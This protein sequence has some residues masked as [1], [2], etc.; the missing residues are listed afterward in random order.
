MKNACLEDEYILNKG[1]KNGMDASK[2]RDI[3]V[4]K[5][6]RYKAILIDGE[7]GIGK[8]YEIRKCVEENTKN[9]FYLSLF[10]IE[11]PLSIYKSMLLEL[12]PMEEKNKRALN[13]IQSIAKDIGENISDSIETKGIL[14]GAVKSVVSSIVNE[15]SI[16]INRLSKIKD[17]IIVFD[18]MERIDDSVSMVC[19]LG[20]LEELKKHTNIVVIANLGKMSDEHKKNLDDYT[21]KIFGKVY[22]ITQCSKII[23]W[24]ELGVDETAKMLFED[25]KQ[26]LNLRVLQ[27]GQYLFDDLTLSLKREYSHEFLEFIHQI[28]YE[29]VVEE[30][31]SKNVEN[32]FV[33]GGNKDRIDCIIDKIVKKY[34]QREH[35]VSYHIIRNIYMYFINGESINEEEFYAESHIYD[36][37]LMVWRMSIDEVE[38]IN[39]KIIQYMEEANEVYE[40]DYLAKK[41]IQ[42][43]NFT[44]KSFDEGLLCYKK[45]MKKILL[46]I[47]E[48]D[49]RYWEKELNREKT[50]ISMLEKAYE[51]VVLSVNICNVDKMID[52]LTKKV[53]DSTAVRYAHW[54]VIVCENK[55]LTD[56]L[57][58]KGEI[59]ISDALIPSKYN[60]YLESEVNYALFTSLYRVMPEKIDAFLGERDIDKLTVS[61]IDV[62]LARK[63]IDLNGFAI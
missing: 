10:G 16:V 18:D 7:W 56:Y 48:I 32:Y 44:E 41:Y 40:L 55:N 59:L 50:Q 33:D 54:L 4:E 21:E 12:Y 30:Y 14:S 31:L 53:Y 37:S 61:R 63:N 26:L 58:K 45:I 22:K 19:L 27:K 47:S 11:N 43:C 57:V 51:E 5:T 20:V 25:N 62:M 6:K 2:I 3:V 49:Y 46:R 39:Q 36:L 9:I 8:T 24:K 17:S 60:N 52:Y 34:V 15:K 13:K 42:V 38:M 23:N 1:D 28:C 29:V 35:I